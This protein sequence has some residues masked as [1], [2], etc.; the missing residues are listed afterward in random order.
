MPGHR[1]DY[2]ELGRPDHHPHQ[3]VTR[4]KSSEHIP[5]ILIQLHWLSAKTSSSHTKLSTL[6]PPPTSATSSKNTAPPAPSAQ[7]TIPSP[8]P[9]HTLLPW[10]PEPS[11]ALHPDYGL[12][13]HSNLT[14][15]NWHSHYD[16]T[17]CTTVID[18][19]F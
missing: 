7:L 4:T 3:I 6:K 15:S 16:W 12:S 9:N 13:Q 5:P 17:L 2:S 19:W 1:S 8:S 18:V 11:A 10:V 14:C